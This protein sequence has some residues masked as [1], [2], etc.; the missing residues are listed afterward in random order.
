[1]EYRG[2]V[3]G[4]VGGGEM[5]EIGYIF[6][7]DYWGQGFAHEVMV[8]VVD[9]AFAN[10]A[11]NHLI[12]DIDPRNDASRRLLL[13]LGFHYTRHARNTFCSD[14][15]WANSDCYAL[16]RPGPKKESI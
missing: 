14:G 6:H 1:M 12:A 16:P 5:P 8:A 10:R 11:V 3:I 13:K 15:V 9:P 7:P 2:R 4:K